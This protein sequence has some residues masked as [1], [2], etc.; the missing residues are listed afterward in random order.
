MACVKECSCHSR[1]VREVSDLNNLPSVRQIDL[2][3]ESLRSIRMM[4]RVGCSNDKYTMLSSRAH[5]WLICCMSQSRCRG[6][7][8]NLKYNI[9]QAMKHTALNE[10]ETFRES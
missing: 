6:W 7:W 1:D 9:S 10:V 8:L 5:W 3:I 4:V 2:Q